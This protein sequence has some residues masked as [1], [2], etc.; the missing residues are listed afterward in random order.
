MFI[1]AAIHNKEKR[2][3]FEALYTEYASCMYKVAYRILKDEYLAQD[4]VH[5]AFIN[6]FNN[7][8]KIKENDCNK[9]RAFL[10]IIVRNISINIYNQRKKLSSPSFEDLEEVLSESG[11]NSIVEEVLINNETFNKIRK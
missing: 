9:T 4:A 5:E 7:F 1:F 11:P 2:S 8:D 6:I 10:V 3:R